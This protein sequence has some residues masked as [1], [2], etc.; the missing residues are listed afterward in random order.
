MFQLLCWAS[1]STLSFGSPRALLSVRLGRGVSSVFSVSGLLSTVVYAM[2]EKLSGRFFLPP[3]LFEFLVLLL[4][5]VA[6]CHN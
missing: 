3:T 2:I 5:R 4:L 1:I 6:T